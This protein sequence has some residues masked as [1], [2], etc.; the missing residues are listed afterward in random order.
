MADDAKKTGV[1][2]PS[3]LTA[4]RVDFGSRYVNRSTDPITCGLTGG[5]MAPILPSR[6]PRHN[7]PSPGLDVSRLSAEFRATGTQVQPRLLASFGFHD[8]A[9]YDIARNSA[10]QEDNM[11]DMRRKEIASVVSK[12]QCVLQILLI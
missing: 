4:C 6:K 12:R 11:P 7:R 10:R 5:R 3:F 8:F 1:S 9:R 2:F